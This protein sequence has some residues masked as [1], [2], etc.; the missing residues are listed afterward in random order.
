[1]S[2]R[3]VRGSVL[4]MMV[5]FAGSAALAQQGTAQA[6]PLAVRYAGQFDRMVK[7]MNVEAHSDIPGIVESTIYNLVQCKS[8]FPD[9]DY[10]RYIQWLD[11][12]AARQTDAA[13]IY[14]ATLASM[15]LRYG[16]P[17]SD[18]SVFDPGDHEK[19][20]KTIAAQLATN[21]LATTM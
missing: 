5:V 21:L 17:V 15:Y 19:A 9:K 7:G 10:T 3:M 14:K 12:T 16:S 8:V 11:E 6:Q 18:N 4:V 1:M 13:L 2:M 20:F